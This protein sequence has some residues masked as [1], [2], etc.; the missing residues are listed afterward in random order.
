MNLES[1]RHVHVPGFPAGVYS[2]TNK[3]SRVMG[4]HIHA[5][6]PICFDDGCYGVHMMSGEYE[7]EFGQLRL[8]NIKTWQADYTAAKLHVRLCC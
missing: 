2:P 6:E 7:N 3:G 4:G 5:H 1:G 8:K